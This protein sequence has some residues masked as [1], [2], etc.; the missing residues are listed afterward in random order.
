MGGF[1]GGESYTGAIDEFVVF[2]DTLSDT[3]ISA[4]KE[5]GMAAYLAV[6]ATG[7]LATQWAGIKA[8]R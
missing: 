4:I 8:A 6:E 2:T 7:K 3:D 5:D 1:G